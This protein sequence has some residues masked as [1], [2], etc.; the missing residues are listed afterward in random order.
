MPS[1]YVPKGKTIPARFE[2]G[3]MSRLDGR[4]E[5]VKGLER[6]YEEIIDDC[7]GADGM[8]RLRKALC[9]RAVFLEFWLRQ[10]E[11]KVLTGQAPDEQITRW[12]QGTNSLLGLTKVLG[13]SKSTLDN[14]LDVLYAP[15]PSQEPANE[16]QTPKPKPKPRK[17]KKPSKPKQEPESDDEW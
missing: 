12:I 13:M 5:L 1:K 4:T 14:A 3:F 16:T 10:I 11:R 17:K 8:S 2:P 6:A 15:Q 9:E 7:G